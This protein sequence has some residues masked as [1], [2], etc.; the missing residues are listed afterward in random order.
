MKTYECIMTRRNFWKL[1]RLEIDVS[2]NTARPDALCAVTFTAADQ[3]DVSF[4]TAVH[5]AFLQSPS[6]LWNSATGPGLGGS[7]SN[8][9][10]VSYPYSFRLIKLT[11]ASTP[12]ATMLFVQSPSRLW[13]TASGTD[14]GESR[15]DSTCVS[16]PYPFRLI[17]L[18]S[19]STPLASML[20][21]QSPSRLW[22]TA[23]GTDSSES[24][25][26]STCVSY[27][28]PFRLIKLTSASTPLATMLFCSLLHGCGKLLQ[29]LVWVE[30]EATP[31]ASSILIRSG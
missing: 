13:Q 1:V 19:A 26:D 29:E 12:L 30:V 14:S 11:S 31:L 27:P 16:Y 9:T 21:V 8:S 25:N 17:K 20:F 18:T 23:S 7:R 24:R 2:F 6:R 22:K 5:D 15:S 3:I 28:Y 4:N 10:C